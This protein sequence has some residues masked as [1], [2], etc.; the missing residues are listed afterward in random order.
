[1]GELMLMS[2]DILIGG[3]VHIHQTSSN[4]NKNWEHEKC[5]ED[6]VELYHLGCHQ[7]V[8]FDTIAADFKGNL[9]LYPKNVDEYALFSPC[10][11]IDGYIAS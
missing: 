4:L 10:T 8:D 1:M 11:F 6:S 5:Y 3:N 9:N 2:F 7:W